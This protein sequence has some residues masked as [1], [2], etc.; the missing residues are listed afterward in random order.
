LTRLCPLLACLSLAAAAR[1]QGPHDLA[2]ADVARLREPQHARYLALP[3]V[4]DKKALDQWDAVLRFW[5]NSLS[6]E[7][8]LV[9]PARV[10]PGL[11]RLDL[12]D[13]GWRA[14]TWEKLADL[15]PW[16]TVK[17]V[18][19]KVKVTK[20]IDH[21]G[22]DCYNPETG[23]TIK[24]LAAG[25]YSYEVVESK[26][27]AAGAATGP[28]VPAAPFAAL[29]KA[30]GSQIPVARLDWWLSVAAVANDTGAGYYDWLGVGKKEADFDD[31]GGVDAKKARALQK[32]IGALVSRSTVTLNNRGLERVP[33]ITGYKWKSRDYLKSTD[34]KNALRL[35]DGD[36][37]EDASEQYLTLPN[38][39][40]AFAL[41]N[42]K[43]E[44]QDAA[45]DTIASDGKAPGTDRRVRNGI[46]CVRCHAEGIRPINDWARKVYQPP[47][48]L[49][50][51]VYEESKRKRAKYL[52]DLQE[53]VEEDQQRYARALKKVNGL[54]PAKNAEA[55]AA[56]WADYVE[57]DRALADVALELGMDK[58][59]LLASLKAEAKATTLDPVLAAL[60]QGLEVRVEHLEELVPL[61]YEVYTRH[62]P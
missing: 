34:A 13:Y 54:T 48:T 39:L 42:G 21:K 16:Y 36:I 44:R 9:A 22:G 7:A 1:A 2:A 11:W 20:Y 29:A 26:G 58:A 3:H 32:E 35:L 41:F 62:K 18:T 15:D 37:Q 56:A 5:A 47:F 53:Q 23:R 31:L 49:E 57:R 27:R 4:A 46:S 45:P 28:W 55:V 51:R 30:T 59:A 50:D 17:V 43:G 40:F 19:E 12:R 52:S 25:R 24:N 38:G 6:R 33:A 8:E 14:E 61:L 60:A 10:A